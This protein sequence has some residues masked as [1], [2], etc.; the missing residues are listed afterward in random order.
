ML[1][2]KATVRP[3]RDYD[4]PILLPLTS[5][6]FPYVYA[7]QLQDLSSPAVPH[8][9]QRLAIDMPPCTQELGLANHTCDTP[10]ACACY[11]NCQTTLD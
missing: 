8:A 5:R 7:Q 3:S 10:A 11:Q 1:E 4:R 2:T 9:V 6:L